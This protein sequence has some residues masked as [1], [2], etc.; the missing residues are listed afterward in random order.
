MTFSE[1]KRQIEE[2]AKQT[3]HLSG[4]HRKYVHL[5]KEGDDDLITFACL[6]LPDHPHLML[7]ILNILVKEDSPPIP[8]YYAGRIPVIVECWKFW[9]LQTNRV[10]IHYD[11]EHYWVE[12]KYGNKANWH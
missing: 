8:S 9:A 2:V 10:H 6:L 4:G 11:S 5:I 3:S 12:D 7:P 1:F